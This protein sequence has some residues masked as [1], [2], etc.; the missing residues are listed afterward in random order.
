[1]TKVE[2]GNAT[3]YLGDCLSMIGTIEADALISD[4]PYGINIGKLS[5]G[6]RYG[7]NDFSQYRPARP[8]D[9]YEIHGDDRPFDPAPFLRFPKVVLWGGI[10]FA[11]RLPE[12]RAWLVWDK[13]EG[14]TSDNQ[15]DCEIAW[16]NLPGP[17]RLMSHLWRGAIRRGEENV[18]NEGRQHPT[19]KPIAVMRR[20]VE[21]CKLAPGSIVCD[22]FM[23]SGTT[24]IA[25]LRAGHK[26][27]GIEI[28]PGHFQTAVRRIEAAVARPELALWGAE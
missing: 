4:P 14:T 26:F 17:A 20:C 13:R 28:N 22:P 7:G 24:G 6:N 1:M 21:M 8:D 11:H 19:Q 18:V 9:Y 25:A 5:G 15:A 12:S 27:I 3:L 2:I 10:H 16:T 23:G